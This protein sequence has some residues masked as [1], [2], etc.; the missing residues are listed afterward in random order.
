MMK[1][2]ILSETSLPPHE[3]NKSYSNDDHD[4]TPRIMHIGWQEWYCFR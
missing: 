4:G 2:S 1:L 3:T